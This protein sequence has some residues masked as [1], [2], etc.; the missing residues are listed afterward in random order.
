MAKQELDPEIHGWDEIEE[1]ASS[2]HTVIAP[3]APIRAARKLSFA[4]TNLRAAVESHQKITALRMEELAKSIDRF[5][6][7]SGKLATAAN[8]LALALVILGLAQVV[9]AVIKK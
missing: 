7:S 4:I 6:D 1:M 8:W 9:V 3:K 2:G 5:N